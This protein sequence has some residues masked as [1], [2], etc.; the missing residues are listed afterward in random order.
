MK[1][2]DGYPVDVT[3][4][5]LDALMKRIT[6]ENFKAQMRVIETTNKCDLWKIHTN[7]WSTSLNILNR[8]IWKKLNWILTIKTCTYEDQILTQGPGFL[9][10]IQSWTKSSW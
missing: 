4:I 3:T 6:P 7:N 8:S 9:D 5:Y 2:K 10:Q 1:S